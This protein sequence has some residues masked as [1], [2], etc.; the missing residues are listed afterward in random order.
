MATEHFEI[1]ELDTDE[2]ASQSTSL[3]QTN[4]QVQAIQPPRPFRLAQAASLPTTSLTYFSAPAKKTSIFHYE[5]PMNGLKKSADAI[6]SLVE[7][8]ENGKQHNFCHEIDDK[9]SEDL[10]FN[11]DDSGSQ[12]SSAEKTHTNASA[13]RITGIAVPRAKYPEPRTLIED[14]PESAVSFESYFSSSKEEIVYGS[15]PPK[16]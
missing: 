4:E 10:L 14:E 12:S 1:F 2:T 13:L 3:S 8:K 7:T 11:I 6:P 16:R 9:L 5:D 15:K